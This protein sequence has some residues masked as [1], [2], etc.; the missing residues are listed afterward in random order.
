MRIGPR[1]QR[2]FAICALALVI[3]GALA[4]AVRAI[5]ADHRDVSAS[6][7]VPT[8]RQFLAST[9]IGTG[10]FQN[11]CRYLTP[12]EQKRVALRGSTAHSCGEALAHA[13]LRLGHKTY[14]TT[15]Q[16]DDDLD[17]NAAGAG[18]A[19]AVR[20]WHGGRSHVFVLVPATSAERNDFMAPATPWR[21][22]SGVASLVPSLRG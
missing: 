16:I 10:G 3:A 1:A 19:M 11:G 9:I 14:T 5:R 13:R 8:V 21:I 7:P 12:A 2:A 20:I 6:G 18:R 4:T 15:R 17:A 22:D